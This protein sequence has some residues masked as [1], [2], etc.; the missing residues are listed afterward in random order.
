MSD[1]DKCD[2]RSVA[3]PHSPPVSIVLTVFYNSEIQLQNTFEKYGCKI[4]LR[5][6]EYKNKL[7]QY[8]YKIQLKNTFEKYSYKIHFRNTVTCPSHTPYYFT[9]HYFTKK[10]C[11]PTLNPAPVMPPAYFTFYILHFMSRRV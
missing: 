10:K 5:N 9:L 2:G 8:N 11:L 6:T 3:C 7:K 1:I 4:H